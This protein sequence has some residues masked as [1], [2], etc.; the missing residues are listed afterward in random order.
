MAE[1]VNEVDKEIE[2][3]AD[4]KYQK[5]VMVESAKMAMWFLPRVIS[6]IYMII[7]I[8]WIMECQGTFGFVFTS[9]FGWHALCMSLFV[10]VFMNEAVL[11]YTIPLL[12]QVANDRKSLR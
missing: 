7:I 11:T 1:N 3:L 9:V 8:V 5:S 6:M 4:T 10:V 2:R 12:P